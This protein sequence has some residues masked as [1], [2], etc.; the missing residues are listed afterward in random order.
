M[1]RFSDLIADDRAPLADLAVGLA[2]RSPDEAAESAK[3]ARRYSVPTG[4]AAEFREDYR[5]KAEADD[6]RAAMASAPK[7]KRWIDFDE[8]RAAIVRDEPAISGAELGR[9]LNIGPSWGFKLL[10]EIRA[11]VAFENADGSWVPGC[12]ASVDVRDL[13]TGEVVRKVRHL[14]QLT[15]S[16]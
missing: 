3:L 5:K 6:A 10:A 9:R 4:V 16:A 2:E 8:N 15:L 7:L 11:A 14:A 13:S 12:A 1:G